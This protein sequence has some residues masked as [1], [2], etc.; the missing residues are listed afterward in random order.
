MDPISVVGIAAASLQFIETSIHGI[1]VLRRLKDTPVKFARLLADAEKSLVRIVQLRGAL[2]DGGSAL[3]KTLSSS[4]ADVLRKTIKDIHDAT[5]D[6]QVALRPIF[7]FTGTKGFWKHV[8]SVKMESTIEQMLHRIR[9]C[10]DQLMQELQVAGLEGIG[11][12]TAKIEDLS[13][14]IEELDRKL[15]KQQGSSPQLAPRSQQGAPGLEQ[16]DNSTPVYES[17][18]RVICYPETCGCRPV[19]RLKRIGSSRSSYS[20]DTRG[21]HEPNCP[22]GVS[23]ASWHRFSFQLLPLFNKKLEFALGAIRNAGGLHLEMPIQ[24][25]SV[26]KR[27]ESAIFQRFEKFAEN[28]GARKL[29]SKAN[30]VY[31]FIDCTDHSRF[32][33]YEWDV[34]AVR[35][36]LSDMHRFL[37][38]TKTKGL[39]SARDKDEHGYTIL[40]EI[41]WIVVLL[42][43]VYSHVAEEIGALL[44][45]VERLGIDRD[46][47]PW[48]DG[49]RYSRRYMLR[50]YH[51]GRL[52]IFMPRLTA[53]AADIARDI[54]ALLMPQLSL[55]R[56][57]FGSHLSAMSSEEF[58]DEHIQLY[59]PA[60]GTGGR[61]SIRDTLIRNPS[62]SKYLFKGSLAR[63]VVTRN[64]DLLEQALASPDWESQ[65]FGHS[66]FSVLDLAVGWAEGLRAFSRV[67]KKDVISAVGLSV[68]ESDRHSLEILCDWDLFKFPDP[69]TARDSNTRRES[70]L[71]ALLLVNGDTRDILIRFLKRQRET[72]SSRASRYLSADELSRL[73]VSDNVSDIL[74]TKALGIYDFMKARSIPLDTNLHPGFGASVYHTIFSSGTIWPFATLSGNDSL[75]IVEGLQALYTSGFREID[76]LDG[77]GRTLLDLLAFQS[78]R[79]QIMLV[80]P[81][82]WLLKMGASPIFRS[83]RGPK[84][85]LFG[86][87]S[88]LSRGRSDSPRLQQALSVVEYAAGVCQPVETDTC[89]CYCSES[90]CLPL[91]CLIRDQEYWSECYDCTTCKLLTWLESSGLDEDDEIYSVEQAVRFTLFRRLGMVHT[92]CRGIVHPSRPPT[93]VDEH[94]RMMVRDDDEELASQLDLLIQA[95]R[96][97]LWVWLDSFDEDTPDYASFTCRNRRLHCR[98]DPGPHVVWNGL[99]AHWKKW[100]DKTSKI[101][102]EPPQYLPRFPSKDPRKDKEEHEILVANSQALTLKQHGYEGLDFLEVIRRHFEA[103][104]EA[105]AQDTVSG[106]EGELEKRRRRRAEKVFVPIKRPELLD[107][108]IEGWKQD[109]RPRWW[110]L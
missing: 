15:D 70:T 58:D 65:A 48:V 90:G 47:I 106:S 109:P 61:R 56:V 82:V 46:A 10:G 75:F 84:N 14:L 97:S 77:E 68:L 55:A 102:P 87:A 25:Y 60:L 108:I 52:N 92:C 67:W 104:L 42:A 64:L 6:L 100:W 69:F 72:L 110:T 91:H 7:G 93:A 28:C 50:F 76:A 88:V 38:D 79:L 51:W 71:M 12:I 53:T 96:G 16:Y 73:G 21:R 29:A 33:E 35:R 37:R 78:R 26:V 31:S 11:S 2:D 63:I 83:R 62:Y 40:H 36:E 89:I 30:N 22:Y 49:F 105:A 9:R 59:A 98:R 24:L 44:Q 66:N 54:L 101:L 13:L 1:K 34:I 41:V 85:L 32:G 4:Q 5:E 8:M 80:A 17:S 3:S 23:D 107:E 39:G 20:F 43:P 57:P 103:E 95:Y 81:F 27:S 74:D 18:H 94:E 99:A 86:L 19:R 45:L